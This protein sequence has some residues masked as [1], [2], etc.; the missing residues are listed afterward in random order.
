MFYNMLLIE[1]SPI[2]KPIY[3]LIDVFEMKK[4]CSS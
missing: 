4:V 2:Y 3:M 1:S